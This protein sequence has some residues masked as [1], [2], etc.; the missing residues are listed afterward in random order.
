MLG[1]IT[2]LNTLQTPH[3]ILQARRE[4]GIRIDS[5]DNDKLRVCL[6]KIGKGTTSSYVSSLLTHHSPPLKI[7]LFTSPHLLSVRER[8]RLN[9]LPL[10]APLFTTYFFHIWDTLP[11]HLRPGYFRFLTLL[12]YHVFLS[13]N[14][15]AAV[16]EVGMGGE[17]DG[18]NIVERPAVSG[19]SSLGIDHVFTLGNTIEE[20]AWH[21]GGIFKAGVPAFSVPQPAGAMRVLEERAAERKV[22]SFEVVD[23]DRRLDSVKVTPDAPFQ[24]QNASLALA[25]TDT[26]LLILD[27]SYT[28][29]KTMLTPSLRAGIENMVF[30]GRF[31]RIERAGVTW[32]L[33]GAHTKESI[34][35]AVGW[36]GGAVRNSKATRILVFNQ[37]GDREAVELLEALYTNTQNERN[38]EFDHVIFCPT[39]TRS[40]QSAKKE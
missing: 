29:S 9:G 36:F 31:E 18:T 33:D 22:A 20:I 30:R 17:Y 12:S 13:E 19:V 28:P 34:C 1:A 23:V 25:L 15:D 3:S 26:V 38:L 32:Y 37:Q 6:Q 40:V 7:G 8:I 27:P 24:R 10:P 5:S 2:L 39:K 21:K 14:V 35:V 16:Y 4:A 11:S